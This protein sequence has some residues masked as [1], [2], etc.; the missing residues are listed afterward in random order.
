MV[1]TNNMNIPLTSLDVKFN[2]FGH[3][4]TR[5]ATTLLM[6]FLVVAVASTNGTTV[7]AIGHFDTDGTFQVVRTYFVVN[8]ME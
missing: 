4:V 7:L 3:V 2:N 5:V 8:G 6:V 1:L